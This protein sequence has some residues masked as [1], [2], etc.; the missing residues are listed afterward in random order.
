LEKRVK[1]EH[2]II[3][4]PKN[5]RKDPEQ[6]KINQRDPKSPPMTAWFGGRSTP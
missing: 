3:R 6:S 2:E 1:K 4:L 5:L